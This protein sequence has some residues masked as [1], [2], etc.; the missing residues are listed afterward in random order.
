MDIVREDRIGQPG[1]VW[2][3]STLGGNPISTAAARAALSVFRNAATYPHLHGL[4]EYLR[5]GMRRVLHDRQVAAQVIGDGPLAQ[6][7]FSREPV[8]DYRSTYRSDRKKGRALMLALFARGIFL[9]P[10]GTNL[11]LSPAHDEAAYDSFCE[12]IDHEARER[13]RLHHGH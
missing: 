1:Y 2:V 9:N 4:G 10:M 7:V 3:A 6:I 8:Q 11:Y 12:R 13:R 5:D